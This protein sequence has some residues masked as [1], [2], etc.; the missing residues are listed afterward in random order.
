MMSRVS[1]SSLCTLTLLSFSCLASEWLHLS[2][3]LFSLTLTLSSHSSHT[4]FAFFL[5]IDCNGWVCLILPHTVEELQSR[6]V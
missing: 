4:Q 6:Q 5:K 3:S 2:L 1:D